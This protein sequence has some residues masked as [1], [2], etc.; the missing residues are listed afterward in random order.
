MLTKLLCFILFLLPPV[1]FVTMAVID[2]NPSGVRHV[3]YD[4]SK[5]SAVIS[6]FFPANRLAKAGADGQQLLSEP[7]YFRLR[8]P[9]NYQQ[10]VVNMD[11][12]NKGQG[13]V[14]LGLQVANEGDWQYEL[15]PVENTNLD[16]LQ[17]PKIVAGG[18]TLWQ[19]QAKFTTINNFLE[20]YYNLNSAAYNFDL[21]KKYV[22]PEYQATTTDTTIDRLIRGQWSLY[23]YVK[24]EPLEWHFDVVDFNRTVGPDTVTLVVKDWQGNEIK[25]YSLPD[26]GQVG[27][28]VG[29]SVVRTLDVSLADLPE[30]VYKLEWQAN[31]DIFISQIRTKQHLIAFIDSLYLANNPEYQDGLPDLKTDPTTILTTARTIGL[32]TA[33]PRGLQSVTIDGRSVAV[34]TVHDEVFTSVRS[35]GPAAVVM[36][37]ND[38]MIQGD[39]LFY[40]DQAQY[41][42]PEVIK[43][44]TFDPAVNVDYV[45]AGYQSPSIGTDA[46]RH[47]STTFDLSKAYVDQRSIRFIISAPNYVDQGNDIRLKS[48]DVTLF[49]APLKGWQA[50]LQALIQ[51][52]SYV[53]RSH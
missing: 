14:Q 15:Q 34:A 39:G 22:I 3:R 51:E 46:V 19:R 20:N 41:F 48:V 40:F 16:Q 8:Y 13:L 36:P 44:K 45:I 18:T 12:S 49:K 11:Y 43:L 28:H 38:L 9:Q 47:T 4:F 5:D 6:R 1:F 50:I 21:L 29:A 31:N 30:G 35:T 25:Q 2:L 26:D 27:D 32:A 10:A 17:W 53:V 37:R 52:L 24:Q 7:V 42:N 33:H 23:T